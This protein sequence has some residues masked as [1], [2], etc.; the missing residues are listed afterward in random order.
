MAISALVRWDAWDGGP[1]SCRSHRRVPA[2]ARRPAPSAADVWTA[3]PGRLVLIACFQHAGK[4]TENLV[5][6]ASSS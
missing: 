6:F 2:Q 5:V 3:V 4:A 1:M